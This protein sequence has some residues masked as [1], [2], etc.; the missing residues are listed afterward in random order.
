[1]GEFR[2]AAD[3]PGGVRRPEYRSGSVV[4]SRSGMGRGWSGRSHGDIPVCVGDR[5]CRLYAGSFPGTDTK[6]EGNPSQ[7]RADPGDYRI[8][9]PYLSAAVHHESG[10]PGGTG[11]GEQLWHNDHGSL[12]RGSENRCLCLS[13][14]AGFRERVFCVCCTELRR[15]EK[16]PDSKRNPV[17][18]ESFG[19]IWPADLFAG[20]DFCTP[21]DDII[22]RRQGSG[23]GGAGLWTGRHP[24]RGP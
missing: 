4:C 2:C 11:A 20:C 16:G 9:G 22:Y 21:A 8:F 3:F 7:K 10:N 12:R 13:A 14:G 5:H 23:R 15:G 19:W 6:R 1:M 18:S 24:F 17:C